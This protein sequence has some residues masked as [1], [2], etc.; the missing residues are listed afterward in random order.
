MVAELKMA[1][2]LEYCTGTVYETQLLGYERFGAVCS[3]GRYDNL[4]SSG[5]DRFPGVGMSIG[6]TRILGLLFGAGALTAARSGPA[7]GL[8]APP[9]GESRPAWD[10]IGRSLRFRRVP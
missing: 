10:R 6:V 1:R 3:G 4:A 7:C 8:V 5:S 9:D 2:G